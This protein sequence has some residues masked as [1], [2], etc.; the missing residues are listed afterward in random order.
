MPRFKRRADESDSDYITRC[1]RALHGNGA[2]Q[3]VM[4][5]GR[6]GKRL[7]VKACKRMSVPADKIP[8]VAGGR[9]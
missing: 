4:P 3:R 1:L 5:V 8:D 9:R 2:M 7:V 6:D